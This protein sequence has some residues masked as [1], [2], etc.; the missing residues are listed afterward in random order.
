MLLAW[1]LACEGYEHHDDG[2][3]D[4]SRAGFDTFYVDDLPA[5]IEVS[6]LAHLLL[7]EGEAENIQ[8]VMLGPSTAPLGELDYPIEATP[9]RTHR[10]GYLVRQTE[11]LEVGFLAESEGVYSI[12]VYV[13]DSKR[14]DRDK[15]A[16]L[17]LHV[18]REPKE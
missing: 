10:P 15:H 1:V 8:L 18:R 2:T 5:R 3:V 11:V 17:F 12:D 9:P 16:T 14:A 13:G 7:Y 6:L 4:I